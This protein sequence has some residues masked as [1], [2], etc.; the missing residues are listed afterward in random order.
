[1]ALGRPTVTSRSPEVPL[2]LKVDTLAICDGPIPHYMYQDFSRPPTTSFYVENIKLSKILQDMLDDLYQP[3]VETDDSPLTG[4]A[5]HAEKSS[6]DIVMKMES[7]LTTFE[8]QVPGH[9]SWNGGSEPGR[10]R[11][12]THQR[13]RHVLHAR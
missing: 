4:R 3:R 10:V 13:Q 5:V 6:I 9:L 7:T 2:P 8:A 1:M 11:D 12:P